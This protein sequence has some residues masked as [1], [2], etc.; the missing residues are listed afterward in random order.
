MTCLFLTIV[1]RRRIEKPKFAPLPRTLKAM[2][3]R[4]MPRI[5]SILTELDHDV[6]VRLLVGVTKLFGTGQ[7][8][9]FFVAEVLAYLFKIVRRHI[10]HL[11][12]A[13]F[14]A[15]SSYTF[16]AWLKSSSS[17]H[18]SISSHASQY[19]PLCRGCSVDFAFYFWA[20]GSGSYSWLQLP[21]S[22]MIE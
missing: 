18:N 19:C 1:N 13:S 6:V 9:P 21:R 17:S 7:I 10:T 12:T 14:F 20:R 3:V 8:L 16:T 4:F 22:V 2:Y 11:C 5:S 15:C